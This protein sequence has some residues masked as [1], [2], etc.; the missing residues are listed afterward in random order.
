MLLFAHG[1]PS[2]PDSILGT[3]AFAAYLWLLKVSTP[4]KAATYA[5]VNPVVA[6]GLGA[7]L[8]NEV[9][10]LRVLAATVVIIASVAIIVTRRKHPPKPTDLPQPDPCVHRAA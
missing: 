3:A 10:S 4:A 9:I 6:L 2:V 8:A 1:R 5:Y 7:L